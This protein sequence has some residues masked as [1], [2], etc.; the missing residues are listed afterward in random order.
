MLKVISSNFLQYQIHLVINMSP[1]SS[2]KN[3]CFRVCLD[4]VKDKL[5]SESEFVLLALLDISLLII[6]QI[7]KFK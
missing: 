2:S 1:N 6:D 4:Q 3:G 7:V 5:R